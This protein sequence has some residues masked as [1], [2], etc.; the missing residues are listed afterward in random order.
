MQVIPFGGCGEFG[1]NL[2]AYVSDGICVVVD[3]G[4][5]MPDDTAPGVSYFLP[6]IQA[7]LRR[8]GPPHAVVFTHGHEDH[9]GAIGHLLLMAGQPV[10][11]YGRRLTLRLAERRLPQLR[12]PR[13]LIDFRECEPERPIVISERRPDRPD[14]SMTVT[15]LAVPH[16]VPESCALLLS[17]GRRTVLHTGDY[18]LEE[19]ADSLA[20]LPAAQAGA[21]SVD[22]LVG[23][24][25]NAIV[26]GRS[27]RE[28]DVAV[29]LDAVLHDPAV[30]GRVAVSLFSSHLE[31]IERFATS[32]ARAGRRLCLLGRGLR[33]TV[34]AAEEVRVLHLPASLLC[35]PDEAAALPPRQVALLC[36]GTQGEPGAALTRLVA[37]I[38]PDS[39]PAFGALRLLPGDTVVLA[40][41]AIPGNERAVGRLCDRLLAAGVAVRSGPE[42][43]ASGHGCRD[44]LCALIEH[45]RPRTLLPVHGSLRQTYAHAEIGESV[46]VPA[47][48]CQNGDVIELGETARVVDHLPITRPAVEGYTVGEV[49]PDT[50][51]QRQRLAQTGIVAIAPAPGRRLRVS[52]YGVSDPGPE[53]TA[54]CSDAARRAEAAL[55]ATG[56][57]GA[58][59]SPEEEEA[60]V[61]RAVREVFMARRG[62]RP[63]LLSLLGGESLPED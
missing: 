9:I 47:L 1:R 12:V 28:N 51:R 32:C 56:A 63:T 34:E 41:R 11:V 62:V 44:E 14:A 54:L 5:Q 35:T 7:L 40:A 48:R 33:E 38:D 60:V 36:T 23:D 15:P 57:A 45:V 43:A 55:A 13:G 22:L 50:L 42:Y 4:I 53:L 18:K 8:C 59:L 29:A 61:V 2:T 39:P 37:S 58:F 25:T 16:S 26:P 27:G 49:G 19:F 6:D 31:R 10:P 24:S 3:C 30:Q 20:R 46:G 52:C 17:D 21:G